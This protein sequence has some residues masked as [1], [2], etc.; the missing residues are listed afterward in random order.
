MA[1][2]RAQKLQSDM[3]NIL[4]DLDFDPNIVSRL[5]NCTLE[6][7]AGDKCLEGCCRYA[8]SASAKPYC[9]LSIVHL[10]GHRTFMRGQ[11][12]PREMGSPF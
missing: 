8:T 11:V 5:N 2:A 12:L 1:P 9:C 3:L 4:K 10:V 7:C 6:Q